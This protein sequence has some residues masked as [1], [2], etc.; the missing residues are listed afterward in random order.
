MW[1]GWCD[2]PGAAVRVAAGPLQGLLDPSI[3]E[4]IREQDE[5]DSQVEKAAFSG[6]GGNVGRLVLRAPVRADVGA[7]SG[8]LQGC[9]YSRMPPWEWPCFAR[10]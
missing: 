4:N 6:L 10:C 9:L 1:E 8:I 7:T 3:L 5:V 2:H